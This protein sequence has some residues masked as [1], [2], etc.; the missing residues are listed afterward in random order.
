VQLGCFASNTGYFEL[1]VTTGMPVGVTFWARSERSDYTATVYLQEYDG[2][3]WRDTDSAIVSGITHAKFRLNVVLAQPTSGQRFR[4]R[5]YGQ[6][7]AY[8]DNIAI[9]TVPR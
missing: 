5:G 3:A 6:V 9:F 1:P 8:L 2:S 4:L 7:G